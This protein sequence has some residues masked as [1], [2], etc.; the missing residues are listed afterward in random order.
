MRAAQVSRVE[1]DGYIKVQTTQVVEDLPPPVTIKHVTSPSLFEGEGLF[2]NS[3]SFS[4]FYMHKLL[5][6][7]TNSP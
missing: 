4:H 3:H 2:N 7:F 5:V 1:E 6:V